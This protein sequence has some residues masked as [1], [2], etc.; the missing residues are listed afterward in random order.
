MPLPTYFTVEPA[1]S[2]QF[3]VNKFYLSSSAVDVIMADFRRKRT[4]KFYIKSS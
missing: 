3:D 1:V 2:T 4:A